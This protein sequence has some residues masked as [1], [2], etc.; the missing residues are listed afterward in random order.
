MQNSNAIAIRL[1][2]RRL[3]CLSYCVLIA[4]V[5]TIAWSEIPGTFVV[6]LIK[7]GFAWKYEVQQVVLP[8]WFIVHFYE[9]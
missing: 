1:T 5:K 6:A 3:S 8:C 9:V 7:E 4:S 2:A